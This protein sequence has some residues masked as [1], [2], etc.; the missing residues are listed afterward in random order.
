M[1]PAILLLAV[2]LGVA[3]FAQA[4]VSKAFSEHG[5]VE[6]ST[7]ITGEAVAHRLFDHANVKGVKV[8]V[9]D[10]LLSDYYDASRRVLVLSP[11][12]F[13]GTTAR[14]I[15]IAAHEA[16]HA[17]QHHANYRGLAP[18]LS[19]L[20][21]T[22]LL[23]GIMF[24]ASAILAIARL[25]PPRGAIWAVV[26]GWGLLLIGNLMTLGVEFD[27]SRRGL[28]GVERERILPKVRER[29]AVEATIAAAAWLRVG[30]VLLSPR[31]MFYYLMPFL[32]WRR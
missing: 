7:G 8:E 30:D 20:R 11:T 3:F 21:M 24:W 25:I 31:L 14:A 27:A 26:L 22:H 15:G 28:E 4:M 2:L 23:G 32:G 10:A 9:R 17:L 16:G 29:E 6:L 18:R 13:E 19:A 12:V 5:E 1:I